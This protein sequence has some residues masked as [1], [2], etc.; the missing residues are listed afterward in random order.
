MRYVKL[1]RKRQKMAV[2]IG[3]ITGPP[4]CGKTTEIM[5][6]I[7]AAC[8]KYDPSE[9]GV[10]SF[11]NASV[12]EV[13]NRIFKRYEKQQRKAL[14]NVRT[15]H[16]H[17]YRILEMAKT[18]VA[19]T[20]QKEF[21]E[22]YPHLAFSNGRI[23]NDNDYTWNAYR[24]KNNAALFNHMQILRNKLIPQSEWN[25]A[26][27][28]M[29]ESWLSWMQ[30]HSLTD[31][32]GML[33]KTLESKMGPM[34]SILFV[35]ESQDL[36]P[37]QHELI[38]NW[39]IRT[40]NTTYAGD[41][42]QCIFRFSGAMPE[43]FIQ[44]DAGWNK[45]LGVSYR[46][47][48]AVYKYAREIA[49]GIEDR[50]DTD[51]EPSKS[52]GEGQVINAMTPDL[53]LEGTH[54]II[55][56]CEYQLKK[57]I[58]FLLRQKQIWHNP[59]RIEDKSWNPQMTKTWRAV[60][61]YQRLSQGQMIGLKDLKI[62]T[63]NLKAQSNLVRG[64]KKE[65]MALEQEPDE[66]RTVDIFGLS[67]IGFT[68]EFIGGKQSVREMFRITGQS[69]TLLEHMLDS[70]ID[71]NKKPRV[72]IGTIHSIKGG[73]ADH[74]WIDTGITNLIYQEIKSNDRAKFD[75]ARVA[76]VAA[77]R[78]RKTVGLLRSRLWNPML[79]RI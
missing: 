70:N 78:A 40:D 16:S 12:E 75:E 32:T 51:Y 36:T 66:K 61:I 43:N 44:L 38:K 25:P 67:S 34:I 1:L 27:Q 28:E 69:S 59:Y 11:T 71:I 41:S 15:M 19:E 79:P 35:D 53:S 18:A 54:M 42:D 60:Q 76:Y 45:H 7:D 21:N 10:V 47:S 56:R 46:N 55:C 20:H 48:P 6:L 33:E 58:H 2:K 9:L 29:H 62:M 24:E 77:T 50:E 57:W 5:R 68:D 73:E 37:L 49:K 3:K 72:I 8:K 63:D 14:D 52:Y 65:I 30:K 39:S 22:E 17:C 74:V 64:A 26:V 31:F 4:G 23:K 13:K